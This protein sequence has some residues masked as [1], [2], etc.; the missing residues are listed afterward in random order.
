MG[1]R[2]LCA[3]ALAVFVS[4][5]AFAAD[6]PLQPVPPPLPP[7]LWT[8]FYAGVNLGGGWDRRQSSTVIGGGEL[9]YNWQ[10]GSFVIGGETDIEAMSLRRSAILTSTNGNGNMVTANTAVDYLGTVRGR[11]GFARDHWLFYG[12]GGLAYT[13]INHNGAGLVGV[14]GTYSE[15][16]FEIG[17]AVGGGVEWLFRD[18]WSAK[19]EYL[20]AQFPARSV[21]YTTTVPPITIRYSGLEFN[22]FRLGVNYHFAP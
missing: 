8:G 21:T 16:P 11:A 3:A 20:Y 12:T 10:F 22:Q 14:T 7:P 2:G 13:T 18:R 1:Y 4:S 15:S 6:L 5:S 19:A 9:G 17:F